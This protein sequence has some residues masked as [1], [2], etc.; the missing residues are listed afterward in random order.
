MLHDFLH[1]KAPGNWIND[2][3]GFVYYRGQYHL[4]YQHFP[5]LPRWGTMHWGHA[6][7]DDLVHWEHRGIALYPSKAYDRNGVFS[8]SAV[9]VDGAL[10]L[11]YTAIRYEEENPDN[12]H[13]ALN[14]KFLASQ[15][16][17]ISPDGVRFDNLSAKR[18]IL[19]V[20]ASPEEGDPQNTRDPR[21]WRAAD[22]S[23]R[24]VLGS[25]RDGV[26]QLLFYRSED[27][28][29]W[30]LANRFADPAL[31]TTLECP[32]LFCLD[33]R[34][35]LLGSPMG[36]TADG[37]HYPDQSTWTPVDFEEGTCRFALRGTPAMVD[38]GLD[39]YAPQTTPD[40]AGRRVLIGWMRMPCPIEHSPDGRAPWRGM[41]SLPRLV[42]WRDGQ[43]CFPVHPNVA[44]RFTEPAAGLS[45]L[46]DHRPVRLQGRIHNGQSWNV[47]GYRIRMENGR[48][49]TDRSAVF[50]NQPDSRLTASTPPVGRDSCA[51]DV[52]VEENLIEIFLDDGRYT[53][54]HV[55]FGLDNTLDGTFDA[56][57]TARP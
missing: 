25:T 50:D 11:Y 35:L 19:P 38:W 16:L 44:A 8:G 48:L 49:C 43:L 9:E 1:L 17:V 52:F 3:N 21:V 18:Q 30:T 57:T 28:L 24:M 10:R 13:R 31:G 15:A 42:V 6:V 32:D 4:F 12:I 26:G 27:G 53:L 56:V 14:N 7:S 55:V 5:Y 22:G 37:L 2:P 23:F 45:P 41:M 40:A 46:A 29:T 54:S 47:G 20:P 36:I 39:L 34:W 33:G 51:L